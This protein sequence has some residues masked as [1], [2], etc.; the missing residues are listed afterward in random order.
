MPMT[1]TAD[2]GNFPTDL[3]RYRLSVDVQKPDTDAESFDQEDRVPVP[4]GMPG[5]HDTCPVV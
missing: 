3:Q 5:K 1:A 4:A 2:L